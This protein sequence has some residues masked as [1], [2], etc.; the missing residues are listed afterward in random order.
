VAYI[1]G[2]SALYIEDVKSSRERTNKEQADFGV[3]P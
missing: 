2:N 1:T 3:A